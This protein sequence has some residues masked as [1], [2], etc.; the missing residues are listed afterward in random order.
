MNTFAILYA[1]SAIA[2]IVACL[3][4][5]VQILKKKNVEGISLQSY[6]MWFVLQLG[7]IPYTI[8]K[9]DALWITA[10]VMWAVYYIVMILLIEH[11]RYPNYINTIANKV[12][13][14][15]RLVPV[16]SK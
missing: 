4:Q 14:T 10:S 13:S 5:I 8:Q 2:S 6:D 15:L 9:G 3:P 16:Q 12:A 11:Y 1:L 7:V